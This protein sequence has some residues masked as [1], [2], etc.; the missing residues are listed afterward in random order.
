MRSLIVY[1]LLLLSYLGSDSWLSSG[2]VSDLPSGVTTRAVSAPPRVTI[3]TGQLEGLLD[4]TGV[5]VFRGIPYAAPPVGER[6]WQPPQPVANWQGV[7][8]AREYGPSCPQ[9]AT[10]WGPTS[11]DC[12][13]LNVYTTA[14]A[15]TNHPARPV[16]VWIHG[17]GYFGGSARGFDGRVLARKG[18]VVVTINYRV[19][20]LGYLAHPA[21]AAESS[22]RS[23]GNYGLLDQIAALQWVQHNIA[24][25]GGNPAQVTLFGESAGGFAV[26]AL[27]ASPLA[28]GL[29]H[30]AILQSGTSIH[31]GIHTAQ[32]AQT[33]A[34]AGA[35]TLGIEEG[36]A[37]AAA[38]RAVD[39][40]RLVEAYPRPKQA[41][42]RGYQ[43]WF[44]PVIDGWAL[45][46]PLDRA[47][48]QDRW[49]RV[50]IMVGTT[51]AEGIRF[52]PQVPARSLPDYYHLLG[53]GSLGDTTGTLARLYSVADT[54]EIL[55][56]SQQLVGDL[57][58]GAPAR[59]LVRLVVATGSPA[60][61]YY[62][63][64]T[65]TD[66]TGRRIEAIHTSELP[67]VFGMLPQQWTA[68]VDK[69]R[70][71]YDS[72]LADALS[73]YWVS[74]ARNGNP[75]GPPA[76]GK[77][78]NWPAYDPKTDAYQELGAQIKSGQA[79]RKPFYDELDRL[80]RQQG[81]VRP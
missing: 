9:L 18:V 77:W 6:R 17:G 44:G 58:F 80:A 8:M 31:N 73:D 66:A 3:A 64:R 33:V 21:L 14:T 47:I 34:L 57:G 28:K 40:Q 7:R 22:H 61:F 24:Q 32:A 55:S 53:N 12:L 35:K 5:L 23:A 50:P 75:N 74:F 62:F 71:P 76:K 45:P 20:P 54:A 27:L 16:M 65:S 67:F 43:V 72:V 81:E 59:A 15:N 49:N 39:V 26:G 56:R 48:S 29:F 63:T 4:S 1:L 11:E 25:F 79:L 37:S 51:A 70:T 36:D 19:G 42:L 30:R 2:L 78:P 13:Y 10:N 41:P 52:Q 38:L 46:L 68:Y 60:Y 69:G